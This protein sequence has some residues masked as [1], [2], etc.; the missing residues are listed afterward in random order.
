MPVNLSASLQRDDALLIVDVQNDFC[1]G[2]SLAVP[3]GDAVVPVLN[4]WIEA[5]REAGIPVF[6]SRD[7]HPVDHISFR[8]RGGPWPVHCVQDTSGARFHPE[9]ALPEDTIRISKGAAFDRDAYSAFDGTG[10]AAYLRERGVRRL[11]IGGL[12]EDVCVLATVKDAC[13][14]DFDTHLIADATR[15]V[16]PDQS[17]VV[18]AE[19]REAGAVVEPRDG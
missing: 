10:L 18:R 7:W 13:A 6:A 15:A 12:A 19:M 17:G 9:L 14:E 11:W 1:P 5:A 2:G 16:D 8:D 3:G 4:R